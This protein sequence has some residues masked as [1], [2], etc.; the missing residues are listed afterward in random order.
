MRIAC[1]AWETVARR[2]ARKTVR[3]KQS[4]EAASEAATTSVAGA[5]TRRALG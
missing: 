4:Q 3:G 1:S 2:T 5:K